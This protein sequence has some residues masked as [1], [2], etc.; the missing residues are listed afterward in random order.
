MKSSISPFTVASLLVAA[1]SL[2]APASGQIGGCPTG[3]CSGNRPPYTAPGFAPLSGKLAV[4]TAV[5]A[6]NLSKPA[7]TIF[8]LRDDLNA[9]LGV[10][11]EPTTGTSSPFRYTGP[12]ATAW[13][14]TN[15]GSSAQP[16]PWLG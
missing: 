4:M 16:R 8:N 5:D 9:S 10:G 2:S 15:S 7:L 14:Q 3:D 12:N 11:W 6:Q 1:G 13:S